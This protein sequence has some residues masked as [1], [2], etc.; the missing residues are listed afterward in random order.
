MEKD[1]S[2]S[3]K[4]KETEM[5]GILKINKSRQEAKG[6]RN[7]IRI[8]NANFQRQSCRDI[9]NYCGNWCKE[10]E[11]NN[12]REKTKDPFHQ[13][14]NRGEFEFGL[15]MELSECLILFSI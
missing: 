3:Q 7:S 1:N 6:D 14:Q 11:K 10:T 2:H 15:E 9:K 4:K 8:L 13:I 5:G 12:K